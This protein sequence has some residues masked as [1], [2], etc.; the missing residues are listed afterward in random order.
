METDL[1]N[2]INELND[3]KST[4]IKSTYYD[5]PKILEALY[6]ARKI[7]QKAPLRIEINYDGTSFTNAEERQLFLTILGKEINDL[8]YIKKEFY[9]PYKLQIIITLVQLMIS[10]SISGILDLENNYSIKET[11]SLH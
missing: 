9:Q 11:V 2:S 8:K 5:L 10:I 6:I 3:I 7:A 1:I 4:L